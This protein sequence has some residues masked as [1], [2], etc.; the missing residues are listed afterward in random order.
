MKK[1][2]LSVFLILTLAGYG[3]N[4]IADVT[5]DNA[6]AQVQSFMNSYDIPGLTMAIAKDGKLKYLRSFGEIDKE[7]NI[8][9]QPYN[10]FRIAS[11]SKPVTAIGIMKMVQEGKIALSDKVFGS[12]GL[13]K[14]HPHISQVIYSDERLDVITVQNLLEH[15]GGWD[16]TIDCFPNP[17]TP[18]PYFFAGCDPINT[19][20]HVTEMYDAPNPVTEEL[21]IRFLMEKGLN[22]DPGTKY[23]YSNIGYLVLSEIIEE[24]S[25]MSYEEYFKTEILHPLGIY[26]M[27]L[28]HNL[29]EN[30]NEREGKYYGY[31]GYTN[32]STYGTGED[33]PWEYGGF[34]LEA[35]DG[36]GGWI[37]TARDLVKLLTAV[38]GFN[39]KPD[40]LNASS[41]AIM[42]EPSAP[43]ANYAKG[44]SVNS[45]NN[46]WH[47]GGLPGT[48]SI[49]VRANS[50]YNFAIFVNT[51]IDGNRGGQFYS[52]LDA[53]G[54]NCINSITSWPDWDLMD[55]PTINAGNLE[56]ESVDETTVHLR[57]SNG[58]G[59]QRMVLARK[60]SSPKEFPKDGISYSYSN[61][62]N[63]AEDLGNENFVVYQGTANEVTVSELES[64]TDYTFRVIEFNQSS[65]TG[66]FPL[67]L[68][69]DNPEAEYKSGS[70]GLDVAQVVEFNIYPIPAEEMVKVNFKKSTGKKYEIYNLNGKVI[71]SGIF[72]S[73]AQEIN[74]SRLSSG[75][76]LI[77]AFDINDNTS[78]RKLIIK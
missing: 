13:L 50:G 10:L 21:L 75:L 58:D 78:I 26:D 24:V 59:Q 72:K 44:W 53:I 19:T 36:H 73:T 4:G 8:E 76:Y 47:T 71:A 20:L 39:T 11:V 6:D 69:G 30:F 29:P 34:N 65:N 67:Y 66:N 46:W 3:Q 70:L 42:T 2:Y 61:T 33:V 74:V 12:T 25:G 5:F 51:R 38:D 63:Q 35:M 62:L 40:I 23:A 32:K 43:F 37:A 48:A 27:S 64:N 60:S 77:K 31:G 1:I 52:D 57:W 45:A 68:L 28:G 18:Y 56:T 54:W 49:L 17:T 9:T 7:N 41:I 15:N 55:T 22:F 16:S 14:D